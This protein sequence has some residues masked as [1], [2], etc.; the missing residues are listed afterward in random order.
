VNPEE[1]RSGLEEVV[2]TVLDRRVALDDGTRP[3]DVDGWDSLAHVIVIVALERR[4]D[5]KFKGTEIADASTVG[6]LV[7]LIELKR[8][9]QPAGD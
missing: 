9:Q 7:R 5:V 4:F 6:D 3:G 2:G 1:I 8:L